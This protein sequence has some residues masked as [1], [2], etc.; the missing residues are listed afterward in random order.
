MLKSLT[1]KDLDGG[2]NLLD[3]GCSG[4]PDEKWRPIRRLVN[5]IGFDPNQAECER[6]DAEPREFLS[7]RHLPYA[8][9]GEDGERELFKTKSI[10]CYSLL[11]PKHEWLER[12]SYADLFEVEGT[13]PVTVKAM[14][15][16]AELAAFD[17]DVVK[18]DSQGLDMEIL[19]NGRDIVSRAFYVETEPGFVEH[20]RGE[21][22]FCQV[23]GLM[24]ELG[25]LLFG[26]TLCGVPRK[27]PFAKRKGKTQV[28]WGQNVWLKDYVAL[29]A[30]G[31]AGTLTRAKALKALL[32][33]AVEGVP[34]FGYEL[35]VCFRG[36]GL[37]SGQE[38]ESLS[39]ES[40]WNLSE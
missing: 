14:S 32:L 27:G 37:L 23:A 28:M 38:L 16:V 8:L 36:K 21:N 34:D 18:V 15:N 25:Y 2:V 24:G 39:S 26:L 7:T 4:A 40:A 1:P 30:E 19:R 35:A 17:A 6:L 11:E 22:T 9:A 33:C 3:I 31:R 29:E 5:Y 20:Y 10:Y 13:I 12:F